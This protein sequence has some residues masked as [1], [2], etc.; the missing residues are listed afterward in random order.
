[1]N[2]NSA[3]QPVVAEKISQMLEER[4][5]KNDRR[6][7]PEVRLPASLERRSGGDRRKTS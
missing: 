2:E 5:N 6:Q 7:S 1:M 4:K 3:I